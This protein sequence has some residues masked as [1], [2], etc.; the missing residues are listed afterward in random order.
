MSWGSAALGLSLAALLGVS[1][2]GKISFVPSNV[3]IS[4]DLA[5]REL[6]ERLLGHGFVAAGVELLSS[7]GFYRAFSFHHPGCGE[8]RF[9]AVPINGEATEMLR[10]MSDSGDRVTY[11]YDSRLWPAPPVWRAYLFESIVKLGHATGLSSRSGQNF[12]PALIA[13]DGCLALGL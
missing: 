8:L 6:T 13:S 9:A 4:R 12:M 1:L 5:E 2:A 11:L 3:E 10:R 7:D